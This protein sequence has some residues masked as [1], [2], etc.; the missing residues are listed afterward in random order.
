MVSKYYNGEVVTLAAALAPP[1]AVPLP[2]VV[3]HAV[4]T[5][6]FDMGLIETRYQGRIYVLTESGTFVDT[7]RDFSEADLAPWPQDKTN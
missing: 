5:L 1:Q 7:I 2:R 3:I 6:K 4:L